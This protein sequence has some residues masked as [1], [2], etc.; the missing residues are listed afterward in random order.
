MD[1]SVTVGAFKIGARRGSYHADLPLPAI[2]YWIA[3]RGRG[4][5]KLGANFWPLLVVFPA[6]A[7]CSNDDGLRYV[8]GLQDT[9]GV[10][11]R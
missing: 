5:D 3:N 4:A 1:R 8:A 10:I 9:L 2:L 11:S 6:V 7:R